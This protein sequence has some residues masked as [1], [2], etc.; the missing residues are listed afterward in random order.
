MFVKIMNKF[1]IQN[2]S[3]TNN[4]LGKVKEKKK[5]KCNFINNWPLPR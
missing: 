1:A 2:P 5:K 3:R 4:A